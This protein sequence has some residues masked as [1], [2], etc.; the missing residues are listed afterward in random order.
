MFEKTNHP[1][2]PWHVVRA[3]VKKTARLEFIRD[4]L[5]GFDYKGKSDKLAKPDPKIVFPWSAK[6]SKLIAK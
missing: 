5:S 4:L 6:E 2:A 3:D 1:A